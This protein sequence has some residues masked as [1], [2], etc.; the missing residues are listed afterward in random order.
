MNGQ[1]LSWSCHGLLKKEEM[2]L[3]WLLTDWLKPSL[4]GGYYR[5]GKNPEQK[6]IQGLVFVGF[7]FQKTKGNLLNPMAK[8][9]WNH[10]KIQIAATSQ[11]FKHLWLREVSPSF[12]IIEF[13]KFSEL[14]LNL[15]IKV[16]LWTG[17]RPGPKLSRSIYII[18]I[19]KYRFYQLSLRMMK[20]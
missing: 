6:M 3:K 20:L 7:W 9:L 18:Q 2:Y 11:L 13:I 1:T 14:L 5:F 4:G 12:K 8:Y 16:F 10:L 17:E 15:S 19:V